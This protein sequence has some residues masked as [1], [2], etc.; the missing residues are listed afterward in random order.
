MVGAAIGG[1]VGEVCDA[2]A[3][4]ENGTRGTL[5]YCERYRKW[6]LWGQSWLFTCV[7]RR[8]VVFIDTYVYSSGS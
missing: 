4:S 5:Q 7:P 3:G 8:V 2:I 1:I 6:E